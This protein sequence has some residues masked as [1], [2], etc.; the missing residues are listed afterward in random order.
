MRQLSRTRLRQLERQMHV[1]ALPIGRL[2]M[3][4]PDLW[5]EEDREA[6]FD[7]KREEALE[8]LV[9]RR[10]GVRPIRETGRIWAIIHYMPEDARDWEDATKAAYLEEHETRPVPLWLRRERSCG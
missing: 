1:N 3:L 10:T 6:F 9:Q 4:L 7:P 2:F 8:D 5:A